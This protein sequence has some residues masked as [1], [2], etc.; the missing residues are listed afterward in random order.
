MGC[1][2]SLNFLA[3]FLRFGLLIRIRKTIIFFLLVGN[4]FVSVYS[5]QL[6]TSIIGEKTKRM[7]YEGNK[8]FSYNYITPFAGIVILTIIINQIFYHTEIVIF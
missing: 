6:I 7:A 2:P 8:F 1:P 4:V 5:L 3:E